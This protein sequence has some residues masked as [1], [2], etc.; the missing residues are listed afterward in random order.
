MAQLQEVQTYSI[1]HKWRSC[2]VNSDLEEEYQREIWDSSVRR[3]FILTIAIVV[4][5]L[6]EVLSR[7]KEMYLQFAIQ[8]FI[9][10]LPILLR[11]KEFFRKRHDYICGAVVSALQGV[12]IL[13]LSQNPPQLNGPEE[14]IPMLMIPLVLPVIMAGI[15]PFG[16][17]AATVFTLILLT[18]HFIATALMISQVFPEHYLSVFL[19]NL[20]CCVFIEPCIS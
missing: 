5:Q 6:P 14:I 9:T 1:I 3:Y 19:T 7:G 16:M 17:F 10:F 2:F 11:N 13:G 4:I 12:G 15:L 8:L 18:N 20:L